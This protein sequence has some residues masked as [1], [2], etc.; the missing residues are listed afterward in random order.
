LEAFD[1]EEALEVKPNGDVD[2]WYGRPSASRADE[3]LFGITERRWVLV[4]VIFP[5]DEQYATPD[6]ANRELSPAD[7]TR[8][9]RINKHAVPRGLKLVID[10]DSD[11]KSER[12]SRLD[13]SWV[14]PIPPKLPPPKSLEAR[15]QS[16]STGACSE[17][18][19]RAEMEAS[20]RNHRKRG[21]LQHRALALLFE[22]TDWTNK[23]I[24][25]ELD[26]HPKSLSRFEKFT[27]ARAEIKSG[28]NELPRGCKDGRSGS[29]DAW[30]EE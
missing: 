30:D 23:R 17:R 25:E 15:R 28:R 3:V 16:P 11:M 24:A 12:Q 1:M 7:T 14:P 2:I 22:H 27:K 26:C 20:S 13:R 9:L 18:E 4:F 6:P 29:I 8:W 19:S 5:G 10:K 21:D